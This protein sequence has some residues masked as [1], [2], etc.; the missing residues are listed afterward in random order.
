[1]VQRDC[2]QPG[3]ATKAVMGRVIIPTAELV[4]VVRQLCMLDETPT[5]PSEQPKEAVT[6]Q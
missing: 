3:G 1:M 2:N 5:D 4:R 6:L